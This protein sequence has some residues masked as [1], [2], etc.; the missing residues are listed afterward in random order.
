[1]GEEEIYRLRDDQFEFYE[2]FR[3]IGYDNAGLIFTR[4]V[5]FI[6]LQHKRS[7]LTVA[8]VGA[9]GGID[10]SFVLAAA[11]S[12]LGEG[13]VKM[14]RLPYDGIKSSC[15]DSIR[16]AE[17]LAEYLGI[18]DQ[19]VITIPIFGATDSSRRSI[20]NSGLP[21]PDQ[22]QL[23]NI[24]ARER[25]KMLYHVADKYKGLVLD[26]CNNTEIKMG[27]MTKHGDGASDYNPVGDLYKVWIWEIAKKLKLVPGEIIEREPSADLIIG[28][29]DVED[30]GIAYEPLDLLLWLYFNNNAGKFSLTRSYYYPEEVVNMVMNRVNAN[31]HKSNPI[32]VCRIM[33][34]NGRLRCLS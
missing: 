18:P 9:S 30:M 6:R 21:E 29:T 14:V 16:Y 2:K 7:G 25:M 31:R 5:D 11:V 22:K 33:D 3:K 23:G 12:A 34:T 26:T 32:P 24:M 27:Y 20:I 4:I 15:D 17:Y 19:N 10:S 13:S 1:M 28:Q 8:V